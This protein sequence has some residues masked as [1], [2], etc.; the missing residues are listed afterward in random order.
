MTLPV[1]V[2]HITEL[3]DRV[4]RFSTIQKSS[5]PRQRSLSKLDAYHESRFRTGIG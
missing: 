2:K 5:I 4:K 3:N 1:I